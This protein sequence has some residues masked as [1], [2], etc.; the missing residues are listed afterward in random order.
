MLLID[1]TYRVDAIATN[2]EKFNSEMVFSQQG[3]SACRCEFV[4]ETPR[5]REGF[6]AL[7]SCIS[8]TMYEKAYKENCIQKS[9]PILLSFPPTLDLLPKSMA[10]GKVGQLGIQQLTN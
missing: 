6:H 3:V 7:S 8:E 2:I 10:K 5:A 1:A 4:S 9:W